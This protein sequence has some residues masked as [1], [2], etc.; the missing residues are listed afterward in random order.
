M[1]ASRNRVTGW[2]WSRWSDLRSCEVSSE[3]CDYGP[4][5][6]T[7]GRSIS[8]RRDIARKVVRN[9]RKFNPLSRKNRPMKCVRLPQAPH[10]FDIEVHFAELDD[11]SA[12]LASSTVNCS[13]RSPWSSGAFYQNPSICDFFF[14][15][16]TGF[17]RRGLGRR[18]LFPDPSSTTHKA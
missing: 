13:R 9:K 2:V 17:R 7:V 6:G 18:N 4:T 10:A 5:A 11:A 16:W 3:S 15:W 8:G 12:A 14:I 1:F